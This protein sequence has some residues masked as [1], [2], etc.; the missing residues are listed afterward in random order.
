MYSPTNWNNV[1]FHLE[2]KERRNSILFWRQGG[3]YF[4]LTSAYIYVKKKSISNFF[5]VRPVWR[6]GQQARDIEQGAIKRWEC[7]FD[8]ATLRSRCS[9]E[10]IFHP[11][12]FYFLRAPSR[13][14]YSPPSPPPPPTCQANAHFS[15]HCAPCAIFNVFYRGPSSTKCSPVR[16][17]SRATNPQ[18]L[19]FPGCVVNSV[20]L[21][22]GFERF[23]SLFMPECPY[24]KR[25]P[26]RFCA[27]ER[28]Q[29]PMRRV[30]SIWRKV[31]S[32]S[33]RWN[34]GVMRKSFFYQ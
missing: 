33:G 2:L 20:N 30:D 14:F 19:A 3:N 24:K 31:N 13:Y 8:T 1:R 23:F 12:Y 6:P 25:A 15:L 21:T 7:I 16:R 18:S 17:F 4:S 26:H 34:N 9:F 27:K 28:L 5:G 11:L 32:R 22:F 29:K 10:I